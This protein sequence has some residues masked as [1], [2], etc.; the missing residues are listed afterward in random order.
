MLGYLE[1]VFGGVWVVAALGGFVGV[2]DEEDF[3]GAALHKTFVPY[4]KAEAEEWTSSWA[5]PKHPPP[6]S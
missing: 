2:C 5:R 6:G 3:V 4:A 1:V